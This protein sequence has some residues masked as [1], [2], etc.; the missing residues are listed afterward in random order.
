MWLCLIA[1]A[2]ACENSLSPLPE[3]VPVDSL[4]VS[5][6]RLTVPATTLVGLLSTLSMGQPGA[7]PCSRLWTSSDPAVAEVLEIDDPQSSE[8]GCYSVAVLTHREGHATITITYGGKSATA[9]LTVTPA[10]QFASV[11]GGA[12]HTCALTTAGTAYCWGANDY[13]QWGVD[14]AAY[15]CGDRSWCHEIPKGPVG[16]GLRF[17]ALSAGTDRT[18]GLTTDGRAH[19]WGRGYG[20]EPVAVP[21]A[22][23]FASLSVGRAHA[24]GLTTDDA[25]YCWGENAE[26]QLGNG[27]TESTSTPV[28]VSATTRFAAISAASRHTC[29]LDTGGEVYCWGFNGNGELGSGTKEPSLVPVPVA[30]DLVFAAV[31]AGVAHSCGLTPDGVAYCWGL[32]E[33]GALGM[34]LAFQP[35]STC[36]YGVWDGRYSCSVE[37]VAVAGGLRFRALAASPDWHD[38]DAFTGG[39]RTCAVTQSGEGYC[40]GRVLETEPCG[41]PNRWGYCSGLFAAVVW[42]EPTRIP[43]A[44]RFAAVGGG[45][46]RTCW[47]GQDGR[48]YCWNNYVDSQPERVP[49]QL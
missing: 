47:M 15:D 17:T 22:A 45:S 46:W 3:Q 5:P 49:G 23:T 2:T 28:R 42:P 7:W 27:E 1:A 31:T 9:A 18:C 13:G 29:A 38:D 41:K 35:D 14:P 37:P 30:G 25:A 8:Y 34:P 24:C 20:R 11:S 40:W 26:G 48:G 43:G 39:G 19:C 10:L 33:G 12:A 36:A 32:D 4:S 6:A 16:D 21:G 44:T